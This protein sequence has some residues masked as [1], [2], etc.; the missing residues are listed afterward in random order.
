MNRILDF[1]HRF[2]LFRL[3]LFDKDQSCE[4]WRPVV[5]PLLA[6]ED[7]RCWCT[8]YR[9]CEKWHQKRLIL[10]ITLCNT[11][12][13]DPSH[14]Q[15]YCSF[16]R[17]SQVDAGRRYPRVHDWRFV[18]YAEGDWDCQGSVSPRCLPEGQVWVFRDT[19]HRCC[20]TRQIPVSTSV[21]SYWTWFIHML[22]CLNA[23]WLLYFSTGPTRQCTHS[24]TSCRWT[25]SPTTDHSYHCRWCSHLSPST[26]SFT[27][28][29]ND[30][31][32]YGTIEKLFPNYSRWGVSST[33]WRGCVRGR[34][35]YRR[36]RHNH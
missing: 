8:H 13:S 31:S 20:I 23:I 6:P 12:Q 21:Y 34:E 35:R 5:H 2:L 27:G 14:M 7:P 28:N 10:A 3:W 16:Y 29:Q 30:S 33:P 17:Y 36:S 22:L 9:Y 25:V 11:H 18:S 26:D 15:Q 24:L 1:H 32:E 19:M 4:V